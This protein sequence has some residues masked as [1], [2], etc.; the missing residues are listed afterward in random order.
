MKFGKSFLS[1]QI[2]EWEFGYMNYKSLK[3][4]IKSISKRQSELTDSFNSNTDNNDD[5]L[6]IILLNDSKIKSELAN[7]FFDLDRNIEKVDEFYNKQFTEYQR[8]LRKISNV[9]IKNS[10]ENSKIFNKINNNN[11]SNKIYNFQFENDEKNEIISILLE[12]RNSIRNLKWFGE[13]NKRGF[14]KILKK[15]DKKIG[16]NKQF[17]YMDSRIFPLQF[18]N[19]SEIM[20]LL[21]KINDFL[22]EL[23]ND[24]NNTTDKELSSSNNRPQLISS[25]SSSSL[26]YINLIENDDSINLNKK[27]IENFR[28]PVLAPLKLL[29]NLLNKSTLNLS[30]K[31]IDLLLEILPILQDNS[32]ISGHNFLHN[33]IISLGKQFVVSNNKLINQFSKLN[34]DDLI[35][36]TITT[37]SNSNSSS[38]NNRLIGAFGSDGINSNDSYKGLFYI[39]NNLP[40]HLKFAILQKDNYKRTPLHYSSQYGLKE[41]TKI[42]IEFIKKWELY[43]INT[44]IDNIEFWGDSEN[45]TPLHLSILGL[46]PKTTKLLTDSMDNKCYL[47][48]KNLLLLAT[49]LDSPDLIEILSNC[50]NID[51]NYVDKNSNESALYIASKLNLIHSVECLL[52]LNANTEI[53]ELSFGWTP[54]FIAAVE[55]FQEIVKLLIDHKANFELTDDSGWTPREHAALRGHIDVARLLTPKDYD[56][57]SQLKIVNNNNNKSNIISNNNDSMDKIPEKSK[58]KSIDNNNRLI[59]KQLKNNDSSNII[60]SPIRS[61]SPISQIITNNNGNGNG[62]GNG[63]GNGKNKIIKSF[64]HS[65]LQKDESLILI[66]LGTT[67]LR[68]TE[69]AIELN[70]I[71]ISKIHNTELDTSLSLI[72][73]SPNLP[74]QPSVILDLPLDDNH[75]GSTAPITFKCSGTDPMD[76]IIYFDIVPTYQSLM[77]NNNSNDINDLNDYE[78]DDKNFINSTNDNNNNNLNLVKKN[79]NRKV[80]GRGI[81]LLKTVYTKVG[82]GKTSLF[83]NVTIPIIESISLEVLGLIRFEFMLATP[84]IHPKMTPGRTDTYWKSLVSTRV[85]GHRGYGMNS[86]DRKSLQLG[87]NTVES[88]IAAASLGASYVEFDVQLTKDNIPVIYHD[89]LVAESG[90]DIP[91]HSLTSEQFLGLNKDEDDDIKKYLKKLGSGSGSGAITNKKDYSSNVTTDNESDNSIENNLKNSNRPRSVSMTETT[92]AFKS[93]NFNDSQLKTNNEISNESK[94]SLINTSDEELTN[95]ETMNIY[96]K[97]MHLTKTWKSKKYKGNS[98]G[99]SIASSFVTLKDLFKKLPKNIGFNMEVKYPMLDES[100]DEDMGQVVPDINLFVDTILEIVYENGNGRDMIFSSFHPDVCILLSLKQPSIPIL[101]LTESGTSKMADIRASSLQQGIRFAKNW[102]LLG[103]VSAAA[104]IVE[105]PRLVN[106]VKSSGLVCVTYGVQNNDP[107]NARLE[108]DAGVDAVIVDSVLAVRKGLTKET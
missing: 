96:E 45:L 86:K 63:S 34:N 50:N 74:D 16:T 19:E 2:P 10:E 95:K 91:M 60:T 79:S 81:A 38:Y 8:R 55:G 17:V 71:P 97:R 44:S 48:N 65:Y 87:E 18:S 108:M 33:H 21:N 49:K 43:P 1:H 30:Y 20:E 101:F 80:L 26:N 7:F 89:F 22:V 40:S 68:S 92:S 13:L 27:L 51:I 64:G 98:R 83:K 52:K 106:V 35:I 36:P 90:I 11:S 85:I 9:L 15:L 100:Q 76:T 84:F 99:L 37:N 102:N 57:Y 72:I 88:F 61:P 46:H 23:S 6:Q 24:N 14:R 78:I 107:K 5:D 56:P 67:D 4:E 94:E 28:S 58:L 75:G 41:I 69:N 77:S 104:P 105:C 3:K 93:F 12:L 31:C 70:K 29:L 62:S 54:I 103:I 39:L 32:D 66:N 47:Q 73:H 53:K 25:I 42:L 82:N 59:L